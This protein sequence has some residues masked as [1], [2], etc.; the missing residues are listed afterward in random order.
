MPSITIKVESKD[1][2]IIGWDAYCLSWKAALQE[3]TV[4]KLTWTEPK[5]GNFE[6]QSGDLPSG[7]YAVYAA[8]IGVGRKIS[9]TVDGDPTIVQPV[10][11]SW[12]M[13]VEAVATEGTQ[14]ARTWYFQNGA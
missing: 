10:G 6:G 2:S 5:K 14:A 12:P 7:I 1:K 9:V 3:Q 8:V 11:E 13:T 4:H